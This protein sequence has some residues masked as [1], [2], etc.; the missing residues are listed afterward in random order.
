MFDFMRV[1]S[2]KF[3]SNSL[4]GGLTNTASSSLQLIRPARIP[5]SWF[6]T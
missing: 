1:S 2:A 5:M 6:E 3:K 4:A